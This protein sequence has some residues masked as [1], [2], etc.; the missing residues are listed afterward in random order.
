VARLIEHPSHG[1]HGTPRAPRR[2]N[3]RVATW[4]APS[5]E[6]RP[7]GPVVARMGAATCA[8]R[9]CRSVVL[10]RAWRARARIL[11]IVCRP[12]AAV[13]LPA[14]RDGVQG[15]RHTRVPYR[16]CCTPLLHAS[17]RRPARATGKVISKRVESRLL[18]PRQGPRDRHGQSGISTRRS[19]HRIHRSAHRTHQHSLSRRNGRTPDG[20]HW[21]PASCR[22][23]VER[24]LP[25][26]SSPM[27]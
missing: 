10:M 21:G 26:R 8:L 2:V 25:A 15:L 16:E 17:D 14:A 5:C 20:G 23:F 1:S 3:R 6:M 11:S 7:I 12:Y 27:P 22:R 9:V 24:A 4:R 13:G 18:R 19:P